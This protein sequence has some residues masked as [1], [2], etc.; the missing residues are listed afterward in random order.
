MQI[1][2][3]LHSSAARVKQLLQK[4]TLAEGR[5][6][7]ERCGSKD[8]QR[9][10][11]GPG[12]HMGCECDHLTVTCAAQQAI[13]SRFGPDGAV[14]GVILVL[15]SGNNHAWLSQVHGSL[16]RI[17][18]DKL[19]T[20]SRWKHLLLQLFCTHSVQGGLL[21]LNAVRWQHLFSGRRK[22]SRQ[23]LSH[24]LLQQAI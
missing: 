19:L 14:Q 9:T 4:T 17:G 16:W 6:S 5:A 3:L 20:R 11:Q 24:T 7:S 23:A 10:Q 13:R 1:S 18:W 2:H 12:Q 22:E 21:G 15:A 8:S